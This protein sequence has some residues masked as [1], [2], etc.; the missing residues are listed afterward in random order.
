MLRKVAIVFISIFLSGAGHSVQ[1]LILL[2]FLILYLYFTIRV[3]PFESS[4]LNI[5]EV[6]S[7]TSLIITVYCGIFFLASWNPESE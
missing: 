4:T 3:K 5:L 1:A 7:M 2:L 6:T